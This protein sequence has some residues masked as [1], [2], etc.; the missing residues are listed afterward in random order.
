MRN[1]GYVLSINHSG[2]LLLR[3]VV[4]ASFGWTLVSV[5]ESG[6]QGACRWV[7][8]AVYCIWLLSCSGGDD[9][10]LWFGCCAGALY[11]GCCADHFMPV[12]VP[13]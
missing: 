5:A 1:V 8:A 6:I 4:G 3:G 10:H 13:V 2:T 7:G 9:S 12:V 11:V